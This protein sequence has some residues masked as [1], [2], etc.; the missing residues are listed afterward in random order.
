ML[1]SA[2]QNLKEPKSFEVDESLDTSKEWDDP[3]EYWRVARH[4]GDTVKVKDMKYRSHFDN[5]QNQYITK[6]SDSSCKLEDIKGILYGGI[7]SRFWLY[8]KDVIYQD[9][10]FGDEH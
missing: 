6:I 1:E 2:L 10:D 9:F 7:S 3:T 5:I 8:R 4:L